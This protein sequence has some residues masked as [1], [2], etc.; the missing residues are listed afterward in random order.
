VFLGGQAAG[1]RDVDCG[2]AAFSHGAAV[3]SRRRHRRG[4]GHTSSARK[5]CG[6]ATL[7]KKM[8]QR[9]FFTCA[10]VIADI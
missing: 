1:E 8:L 7:P 9:I 2:R 3:A 5:L 6:A 10:Q 4:R